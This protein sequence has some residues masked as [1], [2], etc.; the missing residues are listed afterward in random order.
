MT[1]Y[2]FTI[3]QCRF[4]VLWALPYEMTKTVLGSEFLA[5]LLFVVRFFSIFSHRSH[6]VTKATA[7]MVCGG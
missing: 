1:N 3:K 2:K 6:D 5:S 7:K 4:V